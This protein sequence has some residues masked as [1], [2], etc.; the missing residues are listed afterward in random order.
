[1]SDGYTYEIDQRVTVPD[2]GGNKG[3]ITGRHRA[4]VSFIGIREFYDVLM[5]NGYVVERE[6]QRIAPITT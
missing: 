6:T 5:D 2:L 1:M 4:N 3:T